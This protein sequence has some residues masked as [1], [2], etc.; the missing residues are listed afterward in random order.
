M[1]LSESYYEIVKCSNCD[2]PFYRRLSGH[3]KKV[4]KDIKG[5]NARNCSKQCA[6]DWKNK[7]KKP[8]DWKVEDEM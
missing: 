8:I 3:K 6:R 5:K 1:K 4:G 2:K 7:C